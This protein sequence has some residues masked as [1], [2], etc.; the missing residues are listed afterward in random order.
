MSQ[1][2]VQ[3]RVTQVVVEFLGVR[4]EEVTRDANFQNDLG[5][6]SLDEVELVMALEEKFDLVIPDEDAAKLLTVG[7]VIDYIEP[8]LRS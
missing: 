8:R 3:E 6:D 7:A 5:S 2:S 4:A 1:K